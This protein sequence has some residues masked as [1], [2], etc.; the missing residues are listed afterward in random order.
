MLGNGKETANK[1][2][3]GLLSLVCICTRLLK[4]MVMQTKHNPHVIAYARLRHPVCIGKRE[5]V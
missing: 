1:K 4:D 2:V 3:F 5:A